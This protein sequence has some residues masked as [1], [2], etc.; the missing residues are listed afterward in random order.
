M[1]IGITL[2]IFASVLFTVVPQEAAAI[3]KKFVVTIDSAEYGDL[4]N[5]TICDDVVVFFSAIIADFIKSPQRSEFFFTLTLPSGHQ[6]YALVIV[7]GHY[8][9][10]QLELHWFDC[11]WESGWYNVFVEA[12]AV[13]IKGGYDTD[14]L[15]FDPPTGGGR[16]D[17]SIKVML[18]E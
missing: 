12:W 10:I 4:D 9:D 18:C 1:R 15:D 14:A 17:P 16:G 5:D 2:L 7:I 8:R 6:L 13:G 3:P 11:A